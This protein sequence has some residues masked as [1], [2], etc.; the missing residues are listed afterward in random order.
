MS[1][2]DEE[3]TKPDTGTP[4][5]EQ[6]DRAFVLES[7]NDV[8]KTV[9]E[10][11]SKASRRLLLHTEDLEP[12]IFDQPPFLEAVTRLVLNHRDACFLILIQDGRRAIQSN[13]RLIE[14]SR[15]LNTHIQFRRPAAQHRNYHKTFLL[16]DN[17][18]YL[19]CPLPGR[20]EGDA[21]FND[22]GKVQEL[23]NYFMEAWEHAEPDVEMRRLDI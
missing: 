12:A 7:R 18:A 13:N 11:A 15:R 6:V 14:L 10:L 20:Y 19:L 3:T 1:K 5:E 9:V 22:P 23:D 8:S 4:G 17:S 21:S 2:H 16:A